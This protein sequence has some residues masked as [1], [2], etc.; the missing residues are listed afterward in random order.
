MGIELG[1]DKNIG[2]SYMIR[3][4]MEISGRIF[5]NLIDGILIE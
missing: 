5:I 3:M 2:I 4:V 1:Y